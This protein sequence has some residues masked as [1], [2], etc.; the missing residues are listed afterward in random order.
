MIIHLNYT[1]YGSEGTT[2]CGLDIKLP[3]FITDQ[4]RLVHVENSQ[5]SKGPY[6]WQAF[7]EDRCR[8]CAT[9]ADLAVLA[10]LN[11]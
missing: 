9:M 2:V 10:S 8:A 3:G 11:I 5:I 1:I 6:V 4:V 7:P